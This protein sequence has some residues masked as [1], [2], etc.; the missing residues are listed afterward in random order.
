[1]VRTFADAHP[2]LE[3][4][5]VDNGPAHFDHLAREFFAASGAFHAAMAITPAYHGIH[6]AAREAGCDMLLT[7]GFGNHTISQN[8]PWA[9]PEMAA[10]G[11]WGALW[12]AA[13]ARPFDGRPVWRRVAALG[14]MPLL[15]PVL[16]GTLR[17]M[18]H[19]D[20]AGHGQ[21]NPFL[22]PAGQ[23]EGGAILPGIAAV[24]AR[25]R[26]RAQY[27]RE[28]YHATGMGAEIGMGFAQVFGLAQRD[29]THYRPL[30]E[31]F[32]GVPTGQFLGPAQDRWLGRRM[33]MGRMPEAQRLNR[34]NGMFQADWHARLSLQLPDL[35]RRIERIADDPAL[36]GLIDIDRARAA[37]DS[38][39]DQTPLDGKV[40][41]MLRFHLP[42]TLL[43][44]DFIDFTSGR[45]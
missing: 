33:A 3:C 25:P 6:R 41:D 18:I 26:N 17:R 27:V 16:A 20:R 44:A 5:F 14:I 23:V 15:P 11:D 38:W 35:R 45:N 19:G 34:A 42:M 2:G 31:W 4:H 22:I 13:A 30:I 28:L 36:S 1:M 32:A 7:A 29:V 40:A 10:R 24:A 43:T 8:A 21:S 39:P 12:R 37:L 9:W